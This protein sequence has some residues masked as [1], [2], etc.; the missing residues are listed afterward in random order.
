VYDFSEKTP[1]AVI[2]KALRDVKSQS[3]GVYIDW[4]IKSVKYSVD[5]ASRG[6]ESRKKQ[7]VITLDNKNVSRRVKSKAARSLYTC[8][9]AERGEVLFRSRIYITVRSKNGLQ[10][11]RAIRAIRKFLTR[12]DSDFK[13]IKSDLLT[14]LSYYSMMSDLKVDKIRDIPSMITSPITL[15][16]MLPAIE[17]DNDIN[18][19]MLGINLRNMSPYRINFRGTATAKNIYVVGLSGDGKTFLGLNWLLD[20]FAIEFNICT[21]DMKGN[22]ISA[23]AHATGGKTLSSTTESP[24]FVNT[25][26]L[27]YNK[28]SDPISY[29]NNRFAASKLQLVVLAD[30]PENLET[31]VDSLIDEFL[32]SVYASIGVIADNPNTWKRTKGLHPYNIY[33]KF[34]AYM[35]ADIIKKYSTISDTVLSR[36]KMFLDRS[37]PYSYIFREEYSLEEILDSKVLN[38]DYGMLSSTKTYDRAVLRLK[39]LFADLV[40]EEFVRHKKEL[41]QWVFKLDEEHQIA[42]DFQLKMYVKDFTLR[43]AQNQVTVLL[44]N[45]VNAL[46][47]NPI[48]RPIIDNINILVIG[49]VTETGRRFL[50]KEYGLEKY[51]K[52]MEKI[53]NDSRYEYTFLLINRMQKNATTAILKTFVPER[54]R[55]SKLF[56]VVDVESEL[57]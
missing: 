26:V 30:L 24:Y 55:A 53:A 57:G 44:G 7:W 11:K 48:A 17:G 14:H 1:I 45:S 19:S 33:E 23:F 3:P 27:N 40:N 47:Q 6:L 42:D 34:I 18:G 12:I 41:G 39:L 15:A 22:E 38:F 10:K 5:I 43:R 56:K 8:D 29:Y 25:F 35:S 28:K 9:V 32:K 16:E 52:L 37:S 51:E 2:S 4:S 49:K 36:F 50:V 31:T 54:V 13:E 46:L 20:A 21:N